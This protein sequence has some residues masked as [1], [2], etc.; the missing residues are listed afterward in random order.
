MKKLFK[1]KSSANKPEQGFVTLEVLVALLTATGF[2]IL[3]LQFLVGAMAI[4]VQAQEKQ[5]AN[6]LIQEDIE[7]LNELGS[8][9]VEGAAGAAPTCDATVYANSFA[10]ALWAA[11]PAGV[12][13]KN[14]LENIDQDDGSFDT[15]GKQL[16]LQR[17]HISGTANNSA[18]PHRTLKVGYQVWDWNGAYV[19]RVGAA[20]TATDEPI[21]ETY[22]EIIPDAALQCP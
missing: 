7:R 20:L 18:A 4:K 16:A 12:Q 14:V 5:R 11:L 9:L 1:L 8:T 10:Q 21:A 13:T 19:N 15:N 3:S 22:V 6:Q 2:V 17:F